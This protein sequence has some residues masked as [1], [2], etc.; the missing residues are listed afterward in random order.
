MP[1]LR[2]KGVPSMKAGCMLMH[3]CQ[4]GLIDTKLL[5][6]IAS[7]GLRW[8]EGE[9]FEVGNL[10]TPCFHYLLSGVVGATTLSRLDP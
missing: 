6:G 9:H 2:N 10:S 1:I 4:I 7:T 5:P 3:R 8:N